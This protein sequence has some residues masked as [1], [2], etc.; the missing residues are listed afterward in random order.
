MHENNKKKSSRLDGNFFCYCV[1]FILDYFLFL[2]VIPV[3]GIAFWI[4]TYYFLIFFN[5]PDPWYMGVK[6]TILTICAV[7]FALKH[8]A[9]VSIY[10]FIRDNVKSKVKF[11]IVSKIYIYIFAL[12]STVVFAGIFELKFSGEQIS[13]DSKLNNTSGASKV[14]P[15]EES[16]SNPLLCILFT[17]FGFLI[18]FC[19]K[20]RPHLAGGAGDVGR[21]TTA[22]DVF[23]FPVTLF[24]T[25]VS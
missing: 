13:I 7:I 6:F 10:K 24:G 21:E 15:T 5:K 23:L 22:E 20:C 25:S 12:C 8:V 1:L 11:F 4:G 19:I 16:E 14:N 2:I 9:R 17:V 3:C 18:L